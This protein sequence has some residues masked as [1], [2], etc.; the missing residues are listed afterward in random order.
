EAADLKLRLQ[1]QGPVL[2]Y[3]DANRL[4]QVVN[5][6]IDNAIKFSHA[7]GT[8]TVSVRRDLARHAVLEVADTG[9][10][11]TS[12]DLP[13]VCERFYRGDKSRQRKDRSGGTGLGLSICSSIVAAHN[14]TIKVESTLGQGTTVTVTLPLAEA[15]RRDEIGLPLKNIESSPVA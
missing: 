4:R 12:E 11:I 2:I 8:I 14:G 5:N 1:C 7:G 10:G 15:A 9:M 13:H 6:L 3:G